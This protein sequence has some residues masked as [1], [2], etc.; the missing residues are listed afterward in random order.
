[1]AISALR[2]V[3]HMVYARREEYRLGTALPAKYIPQPS[4]DSEHLSPLERSAAD[5][6]RRLF[7]R[8]WGQED[9]LVMLTDIVSHQALCPSQIHRRTYRCMICSTTYRRLSNVHQGYLEICLLIF[10]LLRN[11]TDPVLKKSIPKYWSDATAAFALAAP[12]FSDLAA[13]SYLFCELLMSIF[14]RPEA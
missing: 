8:N 2:T 6:I 7:R 5:P 10:H 11:R 12:S 4:G 1:M 13:E 9:G 3:I 14:S